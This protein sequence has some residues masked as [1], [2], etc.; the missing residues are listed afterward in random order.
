MFQW[1]GRR[2][3]LKHLPKN[4]ICAEIGVW[5]G[6]FSRKILSVTRPKMLHLIDPW[7]FM[8]EYPNR[9][10]GGSFATS[11]SDM[12]KIYERVL[13]EFGDI[14][15][16]H[17]RRSCDALAS[18]PDGHLD[19]VY[20]D[21]DHSYEAVLA[22]LELSRQKVKRGGCIAGDDLDWRPEEGMPVK[23]AV[24]EFLAR[25]NF[26]MRAFGSQFLIQV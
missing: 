14:A 6:E 2:Q 5:K 23:R 12:D 20:I 11:Q 7:L 16:I 13:R 8:G 4:A 17:R 22:D 15:T 19:W 25:H 1:I 3:L 26:E 10:Y 24:D 9:W 21:A 18:L